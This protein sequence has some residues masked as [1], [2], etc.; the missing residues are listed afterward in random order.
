MRILPFSDLFLT[1]K[2]SLQALLLFLFALPL[3]LA[4]PALRESRFLRQRDPCTVVA[5]GY[6]TI[7]DTPAINDALRACGNGGTILLPQDQAY[8]I[9]SPIDFSPCKKCEV[10][11]EGQLYVSRDYE[12]WGRS[13]SVFTLSDVH[14]A[15]IIS[16][17]GKGLIDGQAVNYYL[18]WYGDAYGNRYWKFLTHV[19]NRSSDITIS[20]LTIKNPIHGCKHCPA[21]I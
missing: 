1:M 9:R 7:D 15:T 20:G 3:G 14:G 4:G 12:Y 21:Q 8:S 13:E 2:L 11:I 10:Q 16:K 19:T 18:S 17:T 5:Q 6:E